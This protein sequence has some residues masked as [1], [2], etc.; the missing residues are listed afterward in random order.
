MANK[1]AEVTDLETHVL[2]CSM[3]Y[4][5]LESRIERLENKVDEIILHA[6]TT[7]KLIVRTVL[8]IGGG[9]ISSM[10]VTYFKIL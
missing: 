5:A 2:V 7:N 3:R 8:T 10:L 6:A 4:E 9:V 1:S